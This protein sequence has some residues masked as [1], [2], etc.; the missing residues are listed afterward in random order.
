MSYYLSLGITTRLTIQ[1][2]QV[3]KSFQD[4]DFVVN[5]VQTNFNS[6]NLYDVKEDEAKIEWT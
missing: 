4:L 3:L 1:K 2:E 6:T 5:Y